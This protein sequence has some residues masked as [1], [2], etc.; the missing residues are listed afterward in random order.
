MTSTKKVPLGQRTANI[1]RPVRFSVHIRVLFTTSQQACMVAIIDLFNY[2]DV[3]SNAES[4][5][6]RLADGSMPADD[7]GPWPS[8]WIALFRRW[9]DEGLE[10]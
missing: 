7:S 4:I 8:E 9:I 6:A 3:K 2:S 5:Y 10:P 1:N